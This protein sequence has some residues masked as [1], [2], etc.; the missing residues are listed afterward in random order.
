[1][2]GKSEKRI[3]VMCAGHFL[4]VSVEKC[5]F[6]LSFSQVDPPFYSPSAFVRSKWEKKERLETPLLRAA[7][8]LVACLFGVVVKVSLFYCLFF[9]SLI[10]NQNRDVL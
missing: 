7:A 10:S 1:M 8:C 4:N 9:K 6:A 5:A 3:L 2:G